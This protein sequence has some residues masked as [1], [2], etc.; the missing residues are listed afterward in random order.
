MEKFEILKIDPIYQG[1]VFRLESI[2]A[3]LPDGKVRSYD[4]VRHPGAVA[5]IPLDEQGRIL[6]VRQYRLGSGS[7]LLELPAGTL[8][9]NEAPDACAAREVREETG[10][11]A[12]KIEHLGGFY[13]APGY[14][15][16]FLHIYLATGLYPARLP[17]DEDEFLQVEAIPVAQVF[18]WVR[19]G[20]IQ[21]GKSLAALLLAQNRLKA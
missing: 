5:L 12:Q 20:Q 16:E 14:S 4:I 1:R 11:A 17:G 10:M 13:M 9:P 21:D 6:F 8:E 3:R 2:Q 15:S 18:E 19:S 7:E